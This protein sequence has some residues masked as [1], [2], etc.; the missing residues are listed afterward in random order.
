MLTSDDD[1][2]GG[3]KPRLENLME[4]S[5]LDDLGGSNVFLDRIIHLYR[6]WHH[7]RDDNSSVGRGQDMYSIEVANKETRQPVI[8]SALSRTEK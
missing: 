3:G 4:A 6:S 5:I 2:D 8:M 1:D 7:S